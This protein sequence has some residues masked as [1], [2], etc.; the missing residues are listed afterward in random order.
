M[1]Y[2]FHFDPIDM[3]PECKELRQEVRSFL[4]Q[5][6]E[7]GTFAPNDG[8]GTFSKA[9]ARK[10]GA[11]GWIGM[12]WPKEYGG[13]ER[14]HLERYVVIEEMLAH[15]APTRSYST[16]DRQSGPVILRYG[17]E[18][19]KKTI[20]PKIASGD[21]C[22]CIGLSEPNSG[23]DV[24][25][26]STRA[27]KTDGGWLVNGRKIWTSN[28]HNS[29]YMIALLRTSPKTQENHRHGLTQF[30]IDCK[31]PGITI[32]PIINMSG[33]HDF[34]E[35]FFDDVFV[36]DLHLI[37]EVDMAWKQASDELAYE[38][39]GPDRWLETFSVLVELVRRAGAEPSERLA[40]GIGREVANL[41]TLRRMSA[42]IA[43]MLQ[44]GKTPG[45]EAAVVK[46]LGT[47]WEQSLPNRM[48]LL[49]PPTGDSSPESNDDRF[50]EALRHTT[51][52]APKLT[53]QGGTREV[54]RGIIARGLGLR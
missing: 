31:S 11:K 17:Q 51:L 9:F 35:I 25:A 10:V 46:D 53:I 18:E 47:N 49:A 6:I 40:E 38:R 24:F 12:T 42:S 36:P 37:G 21:L 5:E 30:L 41:A 54:L 15:R 2:N 32:R 43:G 39:S 27:T 13:S 14:S 20:L 48:R 26:A 8:K 1:A 44:A 7:A 19:V 22:F 29:D 16:A 3:P 50:E 34:N 33:A 52:I 45:T 28:A 4:R 23:S